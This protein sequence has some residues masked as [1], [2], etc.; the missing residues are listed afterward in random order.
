MKFFLKN[1]TVTAIQFR[2][3]RYQDYPKRTGLAS[4][5]KIPLLQDFRQQIQIMF[6]LPKQI[7]TGLTAI[8]SC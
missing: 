2:I 4:G 7:E 1:L 6:T 8:Q 5:L 3:I